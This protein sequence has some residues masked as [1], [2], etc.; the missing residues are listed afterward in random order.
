MLLNSKKGENEIYSDLYNM[1]QKKKILKVCSSFISLKMW[2]LSRTKQGKSTPAQLLTVIPASLENL[3]PGFTSQLPF[4]SNVS[5]ITWSL[6]EMMFW[7][8]PILLFCNPFICAI[9]ANFTCFGV[10]L[11]AVA[12]G[13]MTAGHSMRCFLRLDI[14]Y[15]LVQNLLIPHRLQPRARIP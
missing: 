2:N 10:I 5:S 9:T 15:F 11:L 8:V 12:M 13:L 7:N 14:R 1:I 6:T 4:V 3:M